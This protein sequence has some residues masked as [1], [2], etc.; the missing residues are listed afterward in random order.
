MQRAMPHDDKPTFYDVEPAFC[1]CEFIDRHG[2]R[3]HLHVGD[4][5]RGQRVGRRRVADFFAVVEKMHKVIV[6]VVL[7]L[8]SFKCV[9]RDLI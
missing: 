2:E 5:R 8:C 9:E 1:C 7:T 4:A 6:F 3:A